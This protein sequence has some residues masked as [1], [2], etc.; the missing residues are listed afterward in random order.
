MTEQNG[1]CPV[2]GGDKAP[3]STTFTADWDEGVLVIRGV[4]ALLCQQCGEAWIQDQT[5]EQLDRV[6]DE[7]RRKRTVVEVAQWQQVA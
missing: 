7:A 1:R 6:V 3:G 5:A 4:P 2:C